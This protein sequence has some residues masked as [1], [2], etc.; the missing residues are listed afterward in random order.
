VL[1]RVPVTVVAATH[2]RLTPVDHGRHIAE[3]LGQGA[4]LVVVRAPGT[5]ST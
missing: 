3:V 5:A 1:R 4:E 2:D